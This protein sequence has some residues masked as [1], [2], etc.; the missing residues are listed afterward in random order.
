MMKKILQTVTVLL[1]LVNYASAQTDFVPG[2]NVIF[3]DKFEMDPVGDLPAKWNTSGSGEVVMIDNEKWLKVPMP[4]A[5]SP[6]MKKA[7]PE[8]CTI[9]FDVYMKPT[10]GVAPHIMFGLTSL[11]NVST[12]DVYRRYLSLKL[13]GYNERGHLVV[14]KNID[15]LLHKDFSL[16]GYVERPL[17]VS[18]S[19]NGPR[20]R[21]YLDDQKVVDLPK[22]MTPDYRKNFFFA[23]SPVGPAPEESAYI[24]NIRIASGDADARSL[25]IKQLMEQGSVMTNE[26][27]FNPQTNQLTPASQ[28]L[29]DQLGQTL[30]Q[31]PD[32]NIQVNSV[33][34][35]PATEGYMPS[36]IPVA[37][38]KGSSII[39]TAAVKTKADK[40]KA[41]LVN[42]FKIKKDRILTDARVK[43][44]EAAAKSKTA[45]KARQLLTEIV[46]L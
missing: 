34:E 15:D 14:A 38:E 37:V 39:N 6:V 23:C 21:V 33:Q 32:M 1:L 35:A 13:E 40:I 24:S 30:Q 25:L 31:N 28:P 4:S 45:G 42:K 46:K 18:I 10:S 11:S 9:E 26:I 12:G 44:T 22:A 27:Q 41:Y 29:L 19:I 20:F 2:Y 8:N 5:V 7:L 16:E 36:E 3:Q 17:H 43:V